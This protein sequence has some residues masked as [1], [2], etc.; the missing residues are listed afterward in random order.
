MSVKYKLLKLQLVNHN[1]IISRF[2]DKKVGDRFGCGNHT[3]SAANIR[4]LA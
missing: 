1:A 2:F 3:F 4:H